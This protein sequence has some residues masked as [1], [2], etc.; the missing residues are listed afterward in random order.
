ME[1]ESF[2][3]GQSLPEWQN[4]HGEK[5]DRKGKNGSYKFQGRHSEWFM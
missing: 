2:G 1:N 3:Q 5:G 4:M